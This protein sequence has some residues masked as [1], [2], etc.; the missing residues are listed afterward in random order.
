MAGL[1]VYAGAYASLEA[2]LGERFAPPPSLRALVARGRLGTKTG[3]GY[4]ELDAAGI[5]ALE[6]RRDATYAALVE[7]LA[8]WQ[9]AEG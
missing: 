3:G 6:Q 9:P 5:A 8:A 2:G 4:L 7:L 1:D